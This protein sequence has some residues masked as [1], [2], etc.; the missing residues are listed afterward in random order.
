MSANAQ[1]SKLDVE[2]FAKVRRLMEGGA[3][4]GER[5]AARSRAEAMAKAAG[6]TL[7]QAMSKVD[8][9]APAPP[10]TAFDFGDWMER[11]EPGWKAQEMQKR[12]KR[13]EAKAKRRAELLRRHGSAEML[14]EMTLYEQLLFA[15]AT[16]FARRGQFPDWVGDRSAWFTTSIGG[17]GEFDF[18][19]SASPEAIAA[20]RDAYPVPHDLTGLLAESRM[21]HR[22]SRDREAFVDGE[23]RHHLEVYA[24]IEIIERELDTRP[25]ASWEDM[26]ARFEWERFKFERQWIDPQSEPESGLIPRL[27]EDFAILRSLYEAGA[28]NGQATASRRTNADK[29]RDVMSMLDAEPELPDREIA[30]RCGV[31]PQTV[32][33][34]RRRR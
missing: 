24:R 21:W 3:T 13:A 16:P 19:R 22:L 12:R 9:A 1:A 18:L 29:Q 15:A 27:R 31:S 6:M 34:W 33:N 14:F 2:R 25:V 28:Q 5:S 30:R 26:Q 32:G 10:E 23:Y 7:A 8:S 17:A 4:D 20:V 11:R